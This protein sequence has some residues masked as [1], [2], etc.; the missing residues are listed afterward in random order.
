[1]RWKKKIVDN[2]KISDALVAKIATLVETT[3][4]RAVT[5][6]SSSTVFRVLQ[7]QRAVSTA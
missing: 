3:R 7:Q 1:M 5:V 4:D 6:K 2:K